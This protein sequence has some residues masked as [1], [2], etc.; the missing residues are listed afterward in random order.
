MV[1]AVVIGGGGAGIE[2]TAPMAA[3]SMVAAVDGDGIDGV[4]TTAS[5]NK[6]QHPGPHCPC[7][8]PCPSLD[9]DRTVGCMASNDASH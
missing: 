9:K 3:S 5:H 7:P 1:I 6:D 8:H 4:F 2:P